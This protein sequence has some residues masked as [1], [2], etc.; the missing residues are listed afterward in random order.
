MVGLRRAVGCWEADRSRCSH[1]GAT[2]IS[3]RRRSKHRGFWPILLAI[4]APLVLAPLAEQ[5]FKS[6]AIPARF[7]WPGALVT[8]STALVLINIGHLRLQFT[9]L[10]I[11]KGPLHSVQIMG[12][13][14][15]V[16]PIGL[17]PAASFCA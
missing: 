3:S 7:I 14:Q 10:A 6:S 17:W 1:R 4:S 12:A 8:T 15:G 5:R 13:S 16:M 9:F 2:A 11:V